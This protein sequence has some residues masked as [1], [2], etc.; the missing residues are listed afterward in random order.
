MSV[1]MEPWKVA[2]TTTGGKEIQKCENLKMRQR[3]CKYLNQPTNQQC[4]GKNQITVQTT[5]FMLCFLAPKTTY[6]DFCGNVKHILLEIEVDFLKLP[7]VNVNGY[8]K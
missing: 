3:I 8:S 2:T 5:Q 6:K 1:T 4:C 7:N